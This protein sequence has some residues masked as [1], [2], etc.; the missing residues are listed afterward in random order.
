[1]IPH[2]DDDRLSALIDGAGDPADIEHAEGCP[3]CRARLDTWREVRGWLAADPPAPDATRRDAA[4]AAALAA[5]PSEVVPLAP[6]RRPPVLIGAVAAV[7]AA[8]ILVA[9]IALAVS[10][11]G[12]K[13]GGRLS[14]AR[15][16]AAKVAPRPAPAASSAGAARAGEGNAN[17]AGGASGGG[18]SSGAFSPA[19]SPPLGDYQGPGALVAALRPALTGAA[20][21]TYSVPAAD[22]VASPGFGVCVA[23]ATSAAGQHAGTKPVLEAT[24]TYLGSPA[25]VFVF[26]DATRH[27]AVV[28]RVPGCALLADV[29]F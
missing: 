8:V 14:A 28:T 29:T 6:R 23:P 15:P 24:L 21:E 4:V 9:V 5:V 25:Q 27:V 10:G 22:G 13:S 11:H 2:L 20:A 26:P 7:A 17:S 1:V 3:S 19:A 16:P 18:T 12:R